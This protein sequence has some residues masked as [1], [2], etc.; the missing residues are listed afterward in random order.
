MAIPPHRR[1]DASP[2]AATSRKALV[3]VNPKARG[4]EEPLADAFA[5]FDAAGIGVETAPYNEIASPSEMRARSADAELIVVCGGDGTLSGAAAGV[6]AADR[7]LGILPIGTANDLARTLAIPA[8]PAAAAHVIVAGHTRHIDVGEVNGR[9]FFNVASIGMS[10]EIA[11]RLTPELKRRW[12]RLGYAIATVQALVAVRPFHATVVGPDG[13]VR[14]KTLQ[15]AV[16]NGRFYGGGSL[17]AEDATVDD[18]R[19]N[20]YSLEVESVWKLML[21]MR[22]LRRGTQGTWREVRTTDG[23]GFE[24]RTRRPRQ[25]NA[26]G[27]LVTT[28]PARFSIHR[29]AVTVFAPPVP[30]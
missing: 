13:E 28:T 11:R 5:V 21:M 14:V 26:D 29:G 1:S 2:T 24:I 23:D 9:Y 17:V 10:V 8:D 19:L 25:V 12:G 4:G 16:G 22:D 7:P 15:V 20:L 3:L 27:E 30:V 6:I 18:G